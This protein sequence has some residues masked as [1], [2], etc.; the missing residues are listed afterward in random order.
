MEQHVLAYLLIVVVNGVS[1]RYAAHAVAPGLRL[2]TSVCR[3]QPPMV[4]VLA[5][6]RHKRDLAAMAPAQSTA[7]GSG[8]TGPPA[9][10]AVAMVR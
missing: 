1:G 7:W 8:P 5:Q 4:A 10:Q 9:A 6:Y 2:V 3:R